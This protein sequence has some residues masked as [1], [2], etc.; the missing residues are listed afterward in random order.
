MTARY[1]DLE[2]PAARPDEGVDKD[3]N[4]FL[5]NENQ[6]VKVTT[7]DGFTSTNH[8][9]QDALAGA[10][11]QREAARQSWTPQLVEMKFPAD[12]TSEDVQYWS[13]RAAKIEGY[14]IVVVP[15]VCFY[16]GPG[17]QVDHGSEP[18]DDNF[19]YLPE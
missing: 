6:T 8:T 15:K 3:G 17:C 4:H 5:D 10:V 13:A 18:S 9:A 7:P 1:F 2:T 11:S 12:V 19:Q 16:C 14:P